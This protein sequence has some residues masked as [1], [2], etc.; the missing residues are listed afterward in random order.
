MSMLFFFFHFIP[1]E[2]A[3]G[4]MFEKKKEATNHIDRPTFFRT[5]FRCTCGKP[6]ALTSI[7]RASQLSPGCLV[8]PCHHV[9]AR[10]GGEAALLLMRV[11]VCTCLSAVWHHADHF[12]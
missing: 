5:M 8:R 3:A 4:M 6:E 9:R 7:F 12:A 2:E 1:L 10:C 11:N